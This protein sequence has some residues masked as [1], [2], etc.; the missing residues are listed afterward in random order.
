M[1]RKPRESGADVDAPMLQINVLM[2]LAVK[3][4]TKIL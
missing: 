1:M 3:R 4:L 2:F